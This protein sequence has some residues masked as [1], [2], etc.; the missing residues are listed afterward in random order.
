MS[1]MFSADGEAHE[2]R[3]DTCSCLLVLCQ[4]RVGGRSW[5]ITRLEHHRCWRRRTV[6]FQ[7]FNKGGSSFL[8]AFDFKR[9]HCP[10]SLG[11]V[12]V[13][14]RATGCW[15]SRVVHGLDRRGSRNA[16]TA[17]AFCTCRSIRKLQ[18]SRVLRDQPCVERR[19]CG[20]KITGNCTRAFKMNDTFAPKG[21]PTPRSRAYT[22]P[23]VTR[24]PARL[25]FERSGYRA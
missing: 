10:G 22:S 6:Q 17:S 8:A 21:E 18:V 9:Q 15:P 7:R 20:P 23:W 2:A 24:V 12:F 16:A 4:L 25:F 13:A 3:S 5:V 14:T 11:C 1:A 19:N